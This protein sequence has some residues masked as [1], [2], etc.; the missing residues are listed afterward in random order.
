MPC[1]RPDT[2]GSADRSTRRPRR[3]RPVRTSSRAQGW[4]VDTLAD[5]DHLVDVLVELVLPLG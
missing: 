3:S 1:L 2:G 4:L 5:L